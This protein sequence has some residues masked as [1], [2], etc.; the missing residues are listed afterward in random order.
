MHLSNRYQEYGCQEE[1]AARWYTTYRKSPSVGIYKANALKEFKKDSED[2]DFDSGTNIVQLAKEQRM[3]TDVWQA[4]FIAIMFVKG[5]T[6]SY[7]HILKL[8]LKGE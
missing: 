8:K 2:L 4:I 6:D 1:L 7:F 5:D 3:N